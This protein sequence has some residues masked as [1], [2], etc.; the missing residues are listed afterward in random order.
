MSE[1][2]RLHPHDREGKLTKKRKFAINGKALIPE[3]DRKDDGA[4][5]NTLKPSKILKPFIFSIS[6]YYQKRFLLRQDDL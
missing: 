3:K 4:K 2:A 5:V 1:I 6:N